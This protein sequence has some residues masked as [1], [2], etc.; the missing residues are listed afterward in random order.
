VLG[1]DVLGVLHALSP[2]S[3]FAFLA[4][5]LCVFRLGVCHHASTGS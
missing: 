1:R 3:G 4:I 5:T 2:L